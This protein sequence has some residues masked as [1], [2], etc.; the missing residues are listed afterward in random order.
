MVLPKSGDG[1]V[2]RAKAAATVR[3][4]V[5]A[6]V[7]NGPGAIPARRAVSHDRVL[8]RNAATVARYAAAA[9]ADV[10]VGDAITR[11]G[12][13]G[14]RERARGVVVYGAAGVG[15]AIAGEGGVGN[16]DR[17]TVVPYAAAD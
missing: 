16:R 17:A 12:G 15:G 14:N 3:V 8:E 2:G 11:E 7:G 5:V 6:A 13:V 9:A 4:E 10:Y 1:V